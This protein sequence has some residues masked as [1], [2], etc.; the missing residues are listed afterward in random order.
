VNIRDRCVDGDLYPKSARRVG[1]GFAVTRGGGGDGDAFAFAADDE[2]DA[3]DADDADV[4]DR[5]MISRDVSR[6][7][8]GTFLWTDAVSSR[9]FLLGAQ[10]TV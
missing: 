10:V 8:R 6:R 3:D 9:V 5:G 4:D 2:G 1:R 7:A